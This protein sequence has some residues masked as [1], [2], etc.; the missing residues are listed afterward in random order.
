VVEVVARLDEQ[1]Q[2]AKIT[3]AKLRAADTILFLGY[4][5]LPPPVSD[6]WSERL[7][8][9][10]TALGITQKESARMMGVD[11]CTLA[12]WER[13]EREPTGVFATRAERF[14]KLGIEPGLAARIA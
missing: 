10:R 11:P 3:T 2:S 8:G 12:R 13:G 4:N 1:R 5:P 6:K 9:G 7:V 14:L